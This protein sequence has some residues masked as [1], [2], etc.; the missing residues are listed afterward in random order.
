MMKHAAER[1]WHNLSQ[2]RL[3]NLCRFTKYV[4]MNW[5]GTRT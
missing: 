5:K 2:C 3:S 4:R 1:I